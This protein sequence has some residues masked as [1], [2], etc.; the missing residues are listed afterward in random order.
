VRPIWR[1]RRPLTWA[2]DLTAADVVVNCVVTLYMLVG[3]RLEERKL[4]REYGLD[5]TAYQ[6]RVSRWIPWKWLRGR[7][8]RRN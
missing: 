5:Y 4:V 3:S 2:R 6:Q 8:R 7:A 1:W